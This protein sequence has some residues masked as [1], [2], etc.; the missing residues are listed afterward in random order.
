MQQQ[1]VGSP[2]YFADIED[3]PSEPYGA[4]CYS[5]SSRSSPRVNFY[6][7]GP[8]ALPKPIGYAAES[9]SSCHPSSRSGG[10]GGKDS[11]PPRELGRPLQAKVA[12][13]SPGICEQF[14]NL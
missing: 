4:E 13:S 8:G 6:R 14:Q 12:P 3:C 5:S 9:E 10:S 2:E 11:F 1:E 7:R